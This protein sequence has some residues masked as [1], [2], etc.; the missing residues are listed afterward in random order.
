LPTYPGS[1]AIT[2]KIII[3]ERVKLKP[4]KQGVVEV[5][6]SKADVF[7]MNRTQ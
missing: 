6:V 4:E 3:K 1:A 7:E 5:E 2:S